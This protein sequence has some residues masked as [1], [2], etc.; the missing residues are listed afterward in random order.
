MAEEIVQTWATPNDLVLELSAPDHGTNT[1][2]VRERLKLMIE[3]PSTAKDGQ[4]MRCRLV[5]AYGRDVF[6]PLKL[7]SDS[8]FDQT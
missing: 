5:D 7:I 2:K 4:K 3:D 8:T 6:F 1:R